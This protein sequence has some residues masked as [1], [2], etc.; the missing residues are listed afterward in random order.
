MFKSA[1]KPLTILLVTTA[2]YLAPMQAVNSEDIE[3]QTRW[4]LTELFPSVDAWNTERER[5][6]SEMAKLADYQNHLGESS[7]KLLEFSDKVSALQKAT[8]RLYVYTSL[9]GDEDQRDAEAQER[10][11]LA[12][13]V[14]AKFGQTVSFISPEI[15]SIGAD[16]IEDFISQEPE[17]E[18]HAFGLRDILRGADHTLS[19]EAES[20]MANASETLAGPQSIYGLL[21]NASIPWPQMTMPDGTEV[22]LNQSSYTKHRANADR[23]VRK[24]VFDTFFGTWKQYE[25]VLGQILDT[26]VKSHTFTA[27]SRKYEAPLT[28]AVAAAN[29]PATV[30]EKLVAAANDNLG[31]MHRYLKLRQRMLGLPD[32]HYYDI[33]PETTSL[34]REFSLDDAK[35]LTVTSLAPFFGQKYTDLLKEGFAGDWMHVYPQPGKRSGAYMQPG[36]YDVHPYVLLNYNKSF[37]DVSTFSHEWGHAVHSMLSK[38][39]QPYENYSYSIFTAELAS[40]TNEV[41]LQEYLLKQDLSDAERLYYIDRA[42]E[43]IRGTFF[44]QTMFAEFE[45]EIHKTASAGEALSGRKMSEIYLGLLKKYHGHEDG[46]MTI[47][48]A[49]AIEWAYIPHFY[50]NFYVYQYATSISGGTMFAERMLAGD[51]SAKD[52]YIG[53]LAAG[54]SRY[55]YELLTDAGVD[56][57]DDEP[58]ITLIN[59]MNRL[60]DEAETILT[61]MGK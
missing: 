54:G 48:D 29:I 14:Y 49:Y 41:L 19:L 37:E 20:V 1:K 44:R 21:V 43:G 13:S 8:A 22:T 50:Y 10:L 28:A 5:I 36:A 6:L 42:L 18:K 24:Q 17:L 38:R 52:D 58:Y 2:L 11:S 32:L 9:K 7:A 33:Y 51:K 4:N 47:D 16:K 12:R 26:L 39:N 15:L 31:S 57:A 45:L 3:G 59:R 40:T 35:D 34:D 27:D 23:A 60:M 55:P 61:R 53:V 30:Y 46:V 25:P 56:L